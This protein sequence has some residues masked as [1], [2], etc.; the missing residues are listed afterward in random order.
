MCELHLPFSL[1]G[2][3]E[4]RIKVLSRFCAR[5]ERLLGIGAG[6]NDFHVEKPHLEV[7]G[8][9]FEE[10]IEGVFAQHLGGGGQYTLAQRKTPVF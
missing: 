8:E 9:G 7:E 4:Y 5:R 10:W 6:K 1:A 3:E 2:Q